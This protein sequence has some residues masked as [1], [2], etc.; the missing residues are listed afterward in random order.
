MAELLQTV[1]TTK[2]SN[3][4]TKR[5]LS[6][7][8]KNLPQT[9]RWQEQKQRYQVIGQEKCIFFSLSNLQY[10]FTFYKSVDNVGL[11]HSIYS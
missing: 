9:M 10:K 3:L 2:Q 1:K 8:E 6:W 7:L 5:K 11:V 4:V